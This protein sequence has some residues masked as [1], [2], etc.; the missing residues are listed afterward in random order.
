MPVR[1]LIHHSS[2]CI[3]H[4]LFILH[5]SFLVE[6]TCSSTPP[7]NLGGVRGSGGDNVMLVGDISTVGRYTGID[8]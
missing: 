2:F 1:S 6:G 5:S 7:A 3:H 8:E 4:F